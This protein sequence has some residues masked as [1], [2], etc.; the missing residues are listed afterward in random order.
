MAANQ[1]QRKDFFIVGV[2]GAPEAIKAIAFKEGL[3]A[4]TATQSPRG[5]TQK[6]V[7]VGNDIL[8]GKKPSNLNILIPMQL[9][10][11]ENA[12]TAQG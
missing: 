4:A 1:A 8:N 7:Q 12:S 5:M 9:V 2:D 10:T 3:Y 6:A 11:R